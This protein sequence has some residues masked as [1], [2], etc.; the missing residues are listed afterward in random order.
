MDAKNL[1]PL[2]AFGWLLPVERIVLH[3]LLDISILQFDQLRYIVV[4]LL[5]EV[6]QFLYKRIVVSI[7]QRVRQS[8][9]L[10]RVHSHEL[11]R[12]VVDLFLEHLELV[13]LRSVLFW[14]LDP[15]LKHKVLLDNEGEPV[16]HFHAEERT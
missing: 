8:Y 3:S 11:V 7:E 2:L 5:W 14:R 15:I 9:T 1:E 6:I 12:S 13:P 16:L 4:L 10:V